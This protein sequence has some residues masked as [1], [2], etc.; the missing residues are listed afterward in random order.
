MQRFIGRNSWI[1]KK[2][3]KIAQN[4]LTES[5]DRI[6]FGPSERTFH[7]FEILMPY[8]VLCSLSLSD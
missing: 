5:H 1:I 8:D 2:N 3:L 7:S 6:L 4:R